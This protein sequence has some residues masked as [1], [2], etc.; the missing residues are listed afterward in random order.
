MAS[1]IQLIED[2]RPIGLDGTPLASR[3]LNAWMGFPLEVHPHM[4]PREVAHR[5]NPCPLVLLRTGSHGRARFRSGLKIY[6]LELAP[7]QVDVFPDG[8]QMDHGWWDCS[9]GEII[10]IELRSE[11]LHDLLR[12]EVNTFRLRPVLA[13]RDPIL[14]QLIHGV[15]REIDCGCPSGILYAQGVSLAILGCLLDRYAETPLEAPK[16]PRLSEAQAKKVVEYIDARLA[17]RL[18]VARLADLLD[19]S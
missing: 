19:L 2:G 3:P 4:R 15:R 11:M 5:T 18:D 6:D 10:A 16:K 1:H 12:E 9:P 13:A 14:E 8:F 17:T 7:G